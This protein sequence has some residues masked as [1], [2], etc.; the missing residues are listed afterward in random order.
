MRGT[1]EV[2]KKTWGCLAECDV[3]SAILDIYVQ[4]VL[5]IDLYK[6]MTSEKMKLVK[7]IHDGQLQ[8]HNATKVY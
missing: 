5:T 3:L 6:C 7:D 8:S 4:L 1:Y 2:K